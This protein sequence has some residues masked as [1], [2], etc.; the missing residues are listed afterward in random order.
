MENSFFSST[1]FFLLVVLVLAT[2]FGIFYLYFT[3]RNRERMALI[4]QGMDPNLANSDF[5]VIVALIAAGMGGGLIIADLIPGRYG[6]L[7]GFVVAG[8]NIVVY[9]FVKMAC[10]RKDMGGR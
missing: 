6:P 3:T 4:E 5:W 1:L 2:I 8:A 7:L 10:R 9:H